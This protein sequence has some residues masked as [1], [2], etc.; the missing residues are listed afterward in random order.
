MS[1][2]LIKKFTKKKNT[3]IISAVFVAIVIILVIILFGKNA[4]K[5][6][7]TFTT[8]AVANVVR[9]VEIA[10]KIQSISEADLAF[11]TTGKL[12]QLNFDIGGEVLAGEVIAT[13]DSSDISADLREAQA[14]ASVRRAELNIALSG[15]RIETSSLVQQELTEAERNLEDTI[16]EQN[17]LV[18][19][20]NRQLL[21][22]DLEA[23]SDDPSEDM[24]APIISGSYTGLEEGEY[25][26]DVY[27]SSTPS[28]FSFRF[29]GLESGTQ[30]VTTTLPSS[31]GSLGLFVVFDE[32]E[33]YGQ[34]T[35]IVTVPNE[36]SSQ[37]VTNLNTYN[38]A[39]VQRDIAIGEATLALQK[40]QTETVKDT[41]SSDE[42]SAIAR[43]RLDQAEA[44]VA[45]I[46]AQFE[47]T[48]I[49]APFDGV[50]ADVDVQLGEIVTSQS[51]VVRLIRGSTFEVIANLP[52]VDVVEVF[53]GDTALVTVDAYGDSVIWSAFVSRIDPAESL[54]DG[55]SYYEILLTFIN[56]DDRIKSGMTAQIEIQTEIVENSL[57]LPRRYILQDGDRKFV[58]R[59]ID[60][61][62]K[63][64][65]QIQT[66]I[67]GS[68]GIVQILSGL[69]EGDTV[70]IS[71]E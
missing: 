4:S 50:I 59:K 21:S 39:E 57:T 61:K 17:I 23:V 34:S 46:R 38:L 43:A 51:R 71:E 1:S 56:P 9:S 8:V 63:E 54:I 10:G 45:S 33:Y 70:M 25:V 65:V 60:N 20:A 35:W 66:G 36:R 12:T 7:E 68:D 13:L 64:E 49:I 40:A 5:N 53:E 47:K 41:S 2:D 29:S 48:N 37:Y 32:D 22:S 52:E 58:L 16:S 62:N 31:L 15:S 26:L 28:G 6:G 30:S 67:E 42:D 3:R 11:E 44:R 24:V 18:K 19:N 55:V 69:I 14:D 27:S